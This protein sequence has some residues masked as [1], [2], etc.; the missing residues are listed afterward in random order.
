MILLVEVVASVSDG[1]TKKGDVASS[2]DDLSVYILGHT[3][4]A[5]TLGHGDDADL[6]SFKCEVRGKAKSPCLRFIGYRRVFSVLVIEDPFDAPLDQVM[7]GVIQQRMLFFSD[8]CREK[9]GA[10]TLFHINFV[11]FTVQIHQTHIPNGK[12]RKENGGLIHDLL[13]HFQRNAD[14]KLNHVSD[15][16]P[17]LQIRNGRI[18]FSIQTVEGLQNRRR[19]SV[20][21]MNGTH[22]RFP[23]GISTSQKQNGGE[24]DDIVPFL[25][26]DMI[27]IEDDEQECDHL[28]DEGNSTATSSAQPFSRKLPKDVGD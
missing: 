18:S 3:L 8:D 5:P 24:N 20:I 17:H 15:T 9:E 22:L 16:L 4:Q 13:F 7:T 2:T 6:T 26:V 27:R 21:E 12:H 1:G 28:R 25:G 10:F 14:D 23:H 11:H 19:L